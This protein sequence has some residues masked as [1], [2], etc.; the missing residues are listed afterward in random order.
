VDFEDAVPVGRGD[1]VVQYLP[2]EADRLVH[3][4]Q[5]RDRAVLG[6]VLHRVG[7]VDGEPPSSKRRSMSGLSKLGISARTTYPLSSVSTLTSVPEQR[8]RPS[9]IAERLAVLIGRRP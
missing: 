3:R 8:D 1:L 2:G 5:S 7:R 4:A 6:L 9:V